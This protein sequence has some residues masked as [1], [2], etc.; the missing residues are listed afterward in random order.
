MMDRGPNTHWHMDIHPMCS[1]IFHIFIYT[2]CIQKTQS[3]DGCTEGAGYMKQGLRW[4]F[5][6]KSPYTFSFDT[7]GQIIFVQLYF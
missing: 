2:P 3:K 6:Q 7:E 1:Y 5:A 4:L